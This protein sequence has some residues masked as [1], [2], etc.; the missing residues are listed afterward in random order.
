MRSKNQE[1]FL[2][3][4]GGKRTLFCRKG[5]SSKWGQVSLRRGS[6]SRR[7]WRRWRQSA[8][9][10]LGQGTDSYLIFLMSCSKEVVQNGGDPIRSSYKIQPSDLFSN[11][12][13][14]K[15]SPHTITRFLNTINLHC[16]HRVFL[17]WSPEPYTKEFLWLMLTHRYSNPWTLQIQNHIVW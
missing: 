5:C 8:L 9:K 13:N 16:D 17:Q 3:F 15:T 12:K 10:F 6:F 11:R 14:V 7:P 1:R 4:S 2:R